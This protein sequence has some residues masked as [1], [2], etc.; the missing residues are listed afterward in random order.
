MEAWLAERKANYPTKKRIQEK[1]NAE[2]LKSAQTDEG[3]NSS[4]TKVDSDEEK[5]GKLQADDHSSKEEI[6][7]R[8]R[9]HV[10]FDTFQLP[11]GLTCNVNG[12]MVLQNP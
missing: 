11:P 5:L 3:S 4:N 9:S 1:K 10:P 12:V 2:A 6:M 8:D 7:G